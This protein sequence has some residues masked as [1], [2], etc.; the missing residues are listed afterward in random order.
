MFLVAF[1]LFTYLPLNVTSL[2]RNLFSVLFLV[3]V[4]LIKGLCVMMRMLTNFVFLAMYF[5][6][7][8]NISFYPVL[9][10]YLH[11]FWFLLLMMCPVLLLILSQVL[12]ISDV[13]H[14]L[15]LPLNRHL[16][17]S[18]QR[19]A[20]LLGFPG[21]QIGMVFLLLFKLLL[22]LLLC[23]SLILKLLLKSVGRQA[24]QDKLQ[25]LQD[26]HTWDIVPCPVGVKLIGCKWA[27]T[28]E[29][30]A[31]GSI[32]RHKA[33]LVAL[34]NR[35]EYG[36]DYEETFAPVAK[37]TIVRTVMAIV[38]SKGWSLRL[39]DLKNAFLHGDLKE[40]IFMSPP[41]V[42]FPSSF[43]E[44]CRLKRSLYGLKQVPRAWFEKFHTTLLDF[45]FS[46]SQYD[47]SLFFCKTTL[48]IVILL[49]NVDDIVITGFDLQ[50]I[51]QL[52]QRLKSSFHMKDLRPLQYFLGLRF[53][54]CPNGTL[55]HQHNYTQ[56]L[57]SLVCLQD[58][59]SVLTPMEVNLKLHQA[60][61]DLLSNPSMYQ[62]LVGSL[63]YLTITRPN[64]SFVVQQVSQFMHV[65]C[66][67]HLAAIHRLL[68]YLKGTSGRGL[69][70]PS[71]NSL[72]LEGSD[73]DWA[74][75]AD[76]RCSVTGW[77]MFLGNA[78]ISW[79]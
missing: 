70:F 17:L 14:C 47:S 76:K 69:F 51:E 30:R 61:G 74:G 66:Q 29:L 48:R 35:H 28:I 71:R 50:L 58:S 55:L 13:A 78:L 41:P 21:P 56:E 19:P 3:I 62:Q 43:V 63:N 60:N 54:P 15:F 4:I 68:Q 23:L 39:M 64:I 57:L 36:L 59:N 46:R 79:K 53:Q 40:A 45:T 11:L 32:N 2:L 72:Q 7:K 44:V 52:Q 31:D 67:T 22:I 5:F 24:M 75:C 10:L 1:V 37:M 6:K 26:N 65:P 16:I 8:I 12:C 33:C 42:L 18:Y 27:Y 77:C 9:I 38:V 73:D 34:G 25:A 49:V 20:G